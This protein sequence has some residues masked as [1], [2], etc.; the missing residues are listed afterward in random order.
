MNQ[1]PDGS[2]TQG[3]PANEE[4]AADSSSHPSP[5]GEPKK[6][7]GIEWDVLGP[8]FYPSALIILGMVLLAVVFQESFESL[9]SEVQ[10]GVANYF[11]WLYVLAMNFVLG[12]VIFLIGSRYGEIRLGGQDAKP[13]FTWLGWFAMLFSAG[14]GIG[15]LFYGVAE[16]LYHAA[17]RPP[18]ADAYTADA[19][20]QAMGL[21]FLHWGLHPWAVY[22]LVGLALA[23]F[24]YNRGAPLSIRSVFYPL[25]GE[26][27]HGWQGHVID[28]LATVATLFGVATSLGL[29]V[30]QV[31]AGINHLFGVPVSGTIQVA[32]IVVITAMATISVVRGLD[33]GIR[34]LSELNIGLALLLMLFVFILGPTLFLLNGVIENVGYYLQNLPRLATWNETFE[35]TAWQNGWTVFYWGWWIAWSP[36]VG[37]FIARVSRG[38]TIREFLLGVLLVPTSVTFIWMTVFGDTALQIEMFGAGGM[39]AAVQENVPVALFILLENFPLTG[40]T[41]LL[42]VAVI[43]SFFVTSSDSG[44]MVI[45]M[46]TAG[47]NPEPP[48]PQ[49]IFWAV[50][51]G[52][53][54][55]ALLYG[56]GL[57]ALQAA[58]I[59]TGLPFAIVLLAMC[60]SLILSLRDYYPSTMRSSTDLP[61]V[62]PVIRP[63]PTSGTR[64]PRSRAVW[65]VM[66]VAAL[67]VI[68]LFA[69]KASN[70]SGTPLAKPIEQE[71]VVRLASTGSPS[72]VATSNL[73]RAVLE[74]RLGYRCRIKKMGIE[75]VWRDVANGSEDLM[76]CAWLPQTHQPYLKQYASR[77]EV[78]EPFYKGTRSGLMV[79]SGST[80][81][82]TGESGQDVPFNIPVQTIADLEAQAPAFAAEIISVEPGAGVSMNA[83]KAIEQYQLD[84]YDLVEGTEADLSKRVERALR[85][86]EWIVFT[87]W[88]PHWMNHRWSVRFLDDPKGVFGDAG[89][90]HPVV[91]QGFQESFPGVQE[92]L[93]RFRLNSDQ[94]GQLMDWNARSKASPYQNAKRWLRT[95]PGVVDGWL[96]VSG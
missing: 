18:L 78:L 74:E 61:A 17:I 26:K 90:I 53:V 37:M 65:G 85:N 28:V 39:A 45:D 50:T 83:Q 64:K 6:L 75:Q 63:E 20:Q 5:A 48:V 60:V 68:A 84:S 62:P 10:A 70:R 8:V 40:I 47:G 23:F 11:G 89:G 46:I 7:L 30:Q 38:R 88:T 22:A 58:A 52:V 34:R 14:M 43:V 71:S 21:T 35:N 49:R 73:F 93:T 29:G 3:E 25:L 87:G 95:H 55:A 51:E 27:I 2:H 31:N 96:Q 54:A 94:L 32:L 76:L 19:A 66:V 57:V 56:G 13:D 67:V 79:V 82:Q 72:S 44:S 77:V 59:S 12:T 16:P 69:A 41:S 92:L 33:G 81:R 4:S 1:S 91:R 9:F 36:F 15:L 86:E 42:A 80:G 24:S